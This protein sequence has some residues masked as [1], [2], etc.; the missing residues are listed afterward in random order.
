[1]MVSLAR[2]FS[3]RVRSLWFACVHAPRFLSCGRSAL[4][5]AP[6]RVDGAEHIGVGAGTVMQRGAWLY[7]VPSPGQAGRLLVGAGC[8]F[9]YNNH[10]T[11]VR[12]VVIEDHVLTANNVYISDNLHSYEDVGVPIMHQPVRFKNAVLIG[13]GS[14]IGENVCIIGASVGKFCVIGANSVVTH[15]I[16]DFSVAVGSPAVVIRQYDR[17]SA[18]WENKRELGQGK[19]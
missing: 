11:A 17:S 9:G 12:D 10:I 16:P 15:D 14:W 6:F 2:R 8:V 7:C 13:E 19:E 5:Y 4:L 1:M 18:R 3:A